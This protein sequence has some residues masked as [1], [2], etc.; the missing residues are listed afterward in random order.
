MTPYHAASTGHHTALGVSKLR[1]LSALK[2]TLFLK[3]FT[4]L[5]ACVSVWGTQDRA[6]K[7]KSEGSFANQ[8]FPLPLCRSKE[9]N[10]G[11]QA[12]AGKVSTH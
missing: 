4:H 2:P 11:Q 9:S 3:T 7:R 1:A 10:S 12:F 6:H 5:S 8:L